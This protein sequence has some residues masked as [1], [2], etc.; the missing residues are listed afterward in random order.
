ML[1]Q[2]R[3]V[4]KKVVSAVNVN[5]VGDVVKIVFEMKKRGK[6]IVIYGFLDGSTQTFKIKTRVGNIMEHVGQKRQI[7]DCATPRNFNK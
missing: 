2:S 1:K 7:V 4:K 5:K 3:E 6:N